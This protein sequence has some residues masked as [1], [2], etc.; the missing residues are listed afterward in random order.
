M[1]TTTNATAADIASK[2]LLNRYGFNFDQVSE[3]T[4]QQLGEYIAYMNGTQA[5]LEILAGLVDALKCYNKADSEA[6]QKAFS[7]TLEQRYRT[8]PADI[9]AKEEEEERRERALYWADYDD[10]ETDAAKQARE[11][12]RE[13]EIEFEENDR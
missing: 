13:Y 1:T 9:A 3:R 4:P 2:V 6:F 10:E 8:D 11:G 12:R 7:Q 5:D